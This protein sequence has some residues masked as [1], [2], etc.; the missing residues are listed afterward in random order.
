MAAHLLEGPEQVVP[1][2]KLKR[3]LAG[4]AATELDTCRRGGNGLLSAGAQHESASRQG[5][6]WPSGWLIAATSSVWVRIGDPSHAP[7]A[8]NGSLRSRGSATDQADGWQEAAWEAA[9]RRRGRGRGGVRAGG[10]PVAAGDRDE[11]VCGAGPDCHLSAWSVWI[12]SPEQIGG[13][14]AA[15]V[16]EAGEDESQ[17]TAPEQSRPSGG[18]RA[19]DGRPPSSSSRPR[20]GAGPGSV[21]AAPAIGDARE[22]IQRA[23]DPTGSG[24]GA[25]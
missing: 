25:D 21:A 16:G 19:R 7:R 5:G 20:P 22:A 3:P 2:E 8:T 17:R 24:E 10:T 4:E 6:P 9:G 1:S 15:R 18:G 14:Q 12:G 23:T 13:A 11:D